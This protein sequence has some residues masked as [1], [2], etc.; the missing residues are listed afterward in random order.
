MSKYENLSYHLSSLDE[1]TWEAA[2][3]DIERVFGQPLP[4]SARLY[5][6]WWA[7]Q[8]RAQSVA[9]ERAG[10][11]TSAVDIAGEK[12]TFVRDASEQKSTETMKLTIAEAKAGLAA[13]FGV[14]IHAVEITIRG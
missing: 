2:F 3:S 4:Q 6:A 7:N 8:K 5:P 10:W 9:W 1:D 13:N 12:V 14:P 11:K